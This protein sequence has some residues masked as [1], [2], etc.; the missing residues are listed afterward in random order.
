MKGN[1]K[2]GY[3]I[4]D[5]G[6][7]LFQGDSSAQRDFPSRMF[8]TDAGETSRWKTEE[9]RILRNGQLEFPSL[10]SQSI[11]KQV[12]N[13]LQITQVS[14]TGAHIYLVSN[15]SEAVPFT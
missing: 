10:N 12:P 6:P 2:I 15:C 13:F 14:R 11:W 8:M 5:L 7:Q 9:L 3:M 4:E 1:K